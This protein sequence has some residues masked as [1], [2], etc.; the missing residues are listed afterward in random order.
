MAIR[1][2][3]LYVRNEDGEL[4]PLVI[5]NGSSPTIHN[6]F[7]D[8]AINSDALITAGVVGGYQG[9]ETITWSASD[10][11]HLDV[12]TIKVVL[13]GNTNKEGVYIADVNLDFGDPLPAGLYFVGATIDAASITGRVELLAAPETSS[14][15]AYLGSEVIFLNY[16]TIFPYR[17][18]LPVRTLTEGYIGLDVT[19]TKRIQ[20]QDY[21]P[22]ANTIWLTQISITEGDASIFADGASAG[23]SWSGAANASASSGPQP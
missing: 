20:G 17:F 12:P 8:G 19:T 14:P 3:E 15:A 7:P 16:D 10:A 2:V 5:S 18:V 9:T 23:W 21:T 1:G 4:E 6:Y 13:P 22:S 11:P